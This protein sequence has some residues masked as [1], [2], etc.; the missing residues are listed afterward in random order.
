MWTGIFAWYGAGV[1]LFIFKLELFVQCV[2]LLE[3]IVNHFV[4]IRNALHILLFITYIIYI[5]KY[6][7]AGAACRSSESTGP[8]ADFAI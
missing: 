1:F 4:E 3:P 7:L 5:V 6:Y 8:P 2:C